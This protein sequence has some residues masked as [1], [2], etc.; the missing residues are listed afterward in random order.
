[1]DKKQ[2]K[3][4]FKDFS[5][6]EG[7]EFRYK[8]LRGKKIEIKGSRKLKDP[9]TKKVRWYKATDVFYYDCDESYLLNALRDWLHDL[10]RH[11]CDE[12]I[13]YKGKQPFQ[14]HEAKFS[15]L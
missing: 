9:I 12:W 8:F 5:Y 3:Q 4:F 14:P 15:T 2:V 6:K 10:E 1:M 13:L 7:V 11:E